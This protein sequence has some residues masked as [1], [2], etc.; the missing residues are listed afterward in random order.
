MEVGA[1][2]AHSAGDTL[3]VEAETFCLGRLQLSAEYLDE[4]ALFGKRSDELKTVQ[5]AHAVSDHRSDYE[6][7]RNVWDREFQSNHFSRGQLTGNHGTQTSLGNLEAAAMYAD[8]PI[9]P[10]HLYNN[11]Y[12]RT[13]SGVTSSGR[14]VHSREP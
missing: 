11:R 9:L 2:Q 6:Y 7:L 13:I 4:F 5:K 8:V 3:I 14:F 1:R 12:L 10:Q